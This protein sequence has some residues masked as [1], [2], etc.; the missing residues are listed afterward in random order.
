M[1]TQKT[2]GQDTALQEPTQLAFNEAWHAAVML[3]CPIEER[4]QRFRDGLMQN[5]L[6][7][8]TR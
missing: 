4:L 2:V 8:T 1:N 5:R 3:A 7:G 6:L